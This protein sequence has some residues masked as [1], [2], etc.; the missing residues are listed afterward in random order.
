MAYASITKIEKFTS[1]EDNVQVWLNDM[2]KAI[3][4]NGWNN[5]REFKIAF[6]EYFNNNNSI[7]CL[8]NIFTIIKQK[9]TEAVITYLGPIQAD[10]FT[11]LQIL[12]QFIYGLYSSFFQC[13]Y[14]MHPQTLQNTVTNTR[15]F[16]LAE[17]EANYAQA[18]NL[19]MNELSDLNSKLKQ[20]IMSI[21]III[22]SAVATRN[23]YLSELSTQPSIISTK[24]LT[25]DTT[26]NLSTTNLL[27]LSTHHLSTTVL[28]HLLA[29]VS[30]NLSIS[31]NSNTTI[32]LISKWNPK[33]KTNTT[34]LEIVDGSSPTDL[35]LETGYTQ[36]LSSQNYLSHL[37]TPKDALFNNIETNQIQP[38]TTN[39][40]PPATIMENELLVAIFSFKI[41]ELAETSLFSEVTLEEKLIT[42]IYTDAKIDGHSI[43]LILDSGSAGSIITRQLMN[44][45]KIITA[46]GATKTPIG[47]I[48]N[49]FI[50]V[51][52]IIIPI[53]VLNTQE[54]Q[55]NQ[56]D[57]H[58]CIP[59]MCGHFKPI[60]TSLTP[61][62]K[63][64]EEEKKPTWE[65]YQVFWADIKHNKLLPILSWN[66]KGKERREKEL[67]RETNQ[68]YW[69]KE[70]KPI[71][72]CISE[73]KSTFNPDSNFDND[74][75][76][77]NSSSLAQ[78]D[79]ENN[80]DLNFDSNPETYIALLDFSKKQELRWYSD[81][82]ESIMLKQAHDTDAGFNLRYLG[83]DPIKL[84]PH[85]HICID[86]KVVLEIP[87]T[88]MIQLASKSS[89]A[90]KGINIKEKI[91]DTGYVRNII[92]ILQN[93]SEKAYIIEP[94]EKITQ[95]I[96]LPL[97]KVVQ[98]VLVRNKK[99][100]GITVR[101]IQSFK[102]TS[103]INIP[104]NMAEEEIADKKKIIFTH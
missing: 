52:D 12:N 80:N 66:D 14:P 17:L 69:N 37:V 34:K 8:A 100:L 19:V 51:N 64:E 78:N 68:S 44:H 76:K 67:T 86:L 96:F 6:L 53:K 87:T 103:R 38:L 70:N 15:D 94:N 101:E 18:I 47:E 102:S 29:T 88:T 61:L 35:H 84:E 43:K 75:N 33:A 99:E 20:L 72:S 36:N 60:I 45:T 89:L 74:D 77:N 95:A 90:K 27:A 2:E 104:V 3:T 71:N 16:K 22:Q 50:K 5:N 91:I 32:K 7:N 48:D 81:N 28:A 82:N 11:A 30:S 9:E 92:A 41:E 46:D 31:T 93:N 42:A 1:K 55:I 57:Q 65:V 62:I 26:A 24:L 63:L 39:N 73:L 21:I 49:L 25:Y 58:I 59:I 23:T 10:Y 83:K 40:I 85:S 54:L 97:V 4:A 79:Y 98:L 56:N 13:I